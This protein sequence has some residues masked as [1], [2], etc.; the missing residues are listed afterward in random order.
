[1]R[2]HEPQNKH[3]SQ[4]STG[5]K[6]GRQ[7]GKKAGRQEGRFAGRCWKMQTKIDGRWWAPPAVNSKERLS[8]N[9]YL[10][11]GHEPYAAGAE[12]PLCLQSQPSIAA[13]QAAPSTSPGCSGSRNE[14]NLVQLEEVLEETQLEDIS[15]TT[16]RWR[17][18]RRWWWRWWR[19]W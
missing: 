10:L 9:H 15:G 3:I 4:L 12:H 18:W 11:V 5:R 14:P 19:W 13:P 1:M 2:A 6:A 7:E 8:F 17:R 16:W